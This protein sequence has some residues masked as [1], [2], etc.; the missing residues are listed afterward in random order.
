MKRIIFL[1]V[2]GIMS[3]ISFGQIYEP[4]FTYE[5]GIL[6]NDTSLIICENSKVK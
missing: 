4:E 1:F 3:L 5:C 2:F 6:L